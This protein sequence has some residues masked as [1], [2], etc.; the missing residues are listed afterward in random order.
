[1]RLAD[2]LVSGP[3]RHQ[4]RRN[5]ESWILRPP[6][7]SRRGSLV[8]SWKGYSAI[9]AE[10]DLSTMGNFVY[11][12]VLVRANAAFAARFRV[13]LEIPRRMGTRRVICPRRVHG[14]SI[15]CPGL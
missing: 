9:K 12:C 3:G 6:G 8:L 4:D 1:M 7:W 5:S 13:L 2:D 14:E 10:P 11:L 15:S